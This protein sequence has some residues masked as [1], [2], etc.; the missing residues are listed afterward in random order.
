MPRP[1]KRS[2]VSDAIRAAATAQLAVDLPPFPKDP[3]PADGGPEFVVLVGTVPDLPKSINAT[4]GRNYGTTH[5][6]KKAWQHLGHELARTHKALLAPFRGHRVRFTFAL[7]VKRPGACD[8]ANFLGG[9]S[10]KGLTDWLTR[11]GLVV[12]DD[13]NVWLS[14][15]A[16]FWTGGQWRD[17]IRV[18]VEVIPPAENPADWPAA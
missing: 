17:E 10:V 13:N 14:C 8:E 1:P 15:S 16:V 9:I 2:P 6:H 12:P 18:K 4:A 11:T 5:A 3:L 7:P